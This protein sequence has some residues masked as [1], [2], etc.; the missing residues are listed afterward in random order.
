MF[1]I[2]LVLLLGTPPVVGPDPR[3]PEPEAKS[4]TTDHESVEKPHAQL[5][6]THRK[7]SSGAVELTLEQ[8]VARALRT[9]TD[10]RIRSLRIASAQMDVSSHKAKMLPLL[11]V[12]S[13]ALFWN[14]PLE[15]SFSLPP[16]LM[17][18]LALINPNLNASIPPMRVR[19]RV[20]FQTAVTIIQPLTPLLSLGSMLDLKKAEVEAARMEQR[21]EQKRVVLEVQ[22]LYLNSLK[23]EA[24]LR[25]LDQ[26][27]LLL[28]AQRVRLRLLID[29]KVV[30]PAEMAKIDA[31]QADLD[32][33]RARALSAV[34]LTRQALAYLL[35]E[36]LDRF[37]RLSLP[38]SAL[39]VP[40]LGDCT[41]QARRNRPEFDLIRARRRQVH[42]GRSAL[43]RDMF[44]RVVALSQYKF[45]EGFGDFEPRNQWFIGFALSWE[46]QWTEKWR[47]RDKLQL[48]DRELDLQTEKAARGIELEISQKH[49]EVATTRA[50]ALARKAAERAA[51][52][53]H[54]TQTKLFSE[55]LATN[56]DV[57]TSHTNWLKARVERENA[58]WDELAARLDYMQSC[59]R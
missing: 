18:M 46:L 15:I 19:D 41:W 39:D 36:P 55:K 56:T 59:S 23:A 14:S 38:Q 3:I 33:Q 32:A 6:Q 43:S 54:E 44:P 4:K 26:G 12:D 8:A 16:E 31:A 7:A 13:T 51:L 50:I 37:Y 1:W 49:L 22:K 47:E 27:D 53:D 17:D 58:Q 24:F 45:S 20:T 28:E 9:N 10:L 29:A 57:L 2:C 25:V 48:A 30:I 35:G 40:S 21:M 52:V 42:E 11:K 34:L 5:T